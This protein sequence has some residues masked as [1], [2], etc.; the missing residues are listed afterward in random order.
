[1]NARRLIVF[2]TPHARRHRSNTIMQKSTC[3]NN[4]TLINTKPKHHNQD[5]QRLQVS[6]MTE[7]ASQDVTHHSEAA[8]ATVHPSHTI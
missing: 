2:H 1:M 5:N 8:A 6:V 7:A 3:D 4:E